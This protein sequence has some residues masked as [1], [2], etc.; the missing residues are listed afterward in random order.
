MSDG[1]LAEMVLRVAEVEADEK[2]LRKLFLNEM[3][4][5]H[6]RLKTIE[7]ICRDNGRAFDAVLAE[8]KLRDEQEAKDG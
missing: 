7:D 6:A 4:I 8:L 2:D 1:S 3:R 5:M